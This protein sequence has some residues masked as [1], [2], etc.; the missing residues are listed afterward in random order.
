M[1]ETVGDLDI[2][3]AGA[4]PGRVMDALRRLDLVETIAAA[5]E[6]KRSVLLRGGLQVDLRVVEPTA[7][8]A[9]LVYFTGS[10]AHNVRIRE[11]AVRRGLMVNEYGVF[12]REGGRR[13]AGKRERDVYESLGLAEIP[14]TLREDTG[15]VEAAAAGRLP[16][17]VTV[18]DVRG[19]L[20]LHSDWS[21][22]G[23]AS[24]AE[25]LEAAAA[26]GYAY[27]AVT[28]HAENL[29]MNGLSRERML[30]RRR[31][32]AELQARVDLRI[33]DGAELNI[34]IDGSLDYDEDFLAG[35]DFCV[36]SVHTL[37]QRPAA[38]Q[39]ER[40]VRALEHP[41]VN[42]LG[43]PT[44]R[45]I[46]RRPGYEIDLDAIV[47]AAVATGTAIEVNGSPRRLDLGGDL[48]RRAL[49]RGATLAISSDAHSIGDLA[50]IRYGVATAQRG[51]ATPDRVLN[52]RELGG[53]LDFVER[54]RR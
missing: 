23:K 3:V 25:M 4:E 12:E 11:R 44:G 13:L 43:H 17:V 49:E 51:W 50:S 16:T 45:L 2:L 28:D 52:C 34:G 40:I 32:I 41:A 10:K 14:A 7:W 27:V 19:D 53:L 22:D 36:A 1:C 42:V 8:G 38:E 24:L 54:K 20:H 26:R 15:E 33:L 47:D 48:V 21:G 18:A 29:P 46:G 39:T 6:K 9:A 5:G 37:F 35:F 30:A 31:A